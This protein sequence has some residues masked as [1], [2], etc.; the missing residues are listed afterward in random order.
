MPVSNWQ[1]QGS[2]VRIQPETEQKSKNAK[3]FPFKTYR[4]IDNC[5]QPFKLHWK[6]SLV[7]QKP[8]RIDKEGRWQGRRAVHPQKSV[9]QS[10]VTLPQRSSSAK[11][12]FPFYCQKNMSGTCHNPPAPAKTGF[13]P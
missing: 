11:N 2:R 5:I 6:S 3:N 12:L 4:G 10:S 1:S 8:L 9:L 7:V 13:H